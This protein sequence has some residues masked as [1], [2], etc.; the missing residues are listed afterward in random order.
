MCSGS[1]SGRGPCFSANQ[2]CHEGVDTV[3]SESHVISTET[4]SMAQ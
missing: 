1:V 4:H 3:D 2:V